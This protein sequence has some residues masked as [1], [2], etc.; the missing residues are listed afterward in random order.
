LPKNHLKTIGKREFRR[1]NIRNLNWFGGS[2]SPCRLA[3]AQSNQSKNDPE[4]GFEP[5]LTNHHARLPLMY[6]EKNDS[7]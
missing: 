2:L 1:L 7:F 5:G 6:F 3:Q 4:T